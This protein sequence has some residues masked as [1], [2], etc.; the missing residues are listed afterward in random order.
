LYKISEEIRHFN[1]QI[2][3]YESWPNK[4]SITNLKFLSYPNNISLGGKNFVVNQP[5]AKVWKEKMGS[6]SLVRST[7]PNNNID[8]SNAT[9]IDG[10]AHLVVI[11]DGL[12]KP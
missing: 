6:T 8:S 11:E 12:L 1:Y 3:S 10:D 9:L 7:T 5:A 2:H 4:F